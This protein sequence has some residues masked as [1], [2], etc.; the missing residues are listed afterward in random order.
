LFDQNRREAQVARIATL[1]LAM[2]FSF[3]LFTC[4][5]MFTRRF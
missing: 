4:L 5:H 1:I 3:L 2:L